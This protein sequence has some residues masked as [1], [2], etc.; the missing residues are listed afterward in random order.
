MH[1]KKA[2]IKGKRWLRGDIVMVY[3]IVH[4]VKKVDRW[5]ICSVSP[6]YRISLG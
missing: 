5:S 3:K 2:L 1:V 4:Q 6:K